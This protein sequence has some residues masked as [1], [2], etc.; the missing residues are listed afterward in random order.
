MYDNAVCFVNPLFA[1]PAAGGSDDWAVGSLNIPYAYTLELRP[2]PVVP[3]LVHFDPP[4]SAI[5]PTS[6]ELRHGAAAMLARILFVI[7]VDVANER[8]RAQ[9]H[10]IRQYAMHR[11][12]RATNTRTTATALNCTH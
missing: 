2:D 9:M 11:S 7:G 3:R 6:D 5:G 10:R 4:A 1:D 12:Y 8:T